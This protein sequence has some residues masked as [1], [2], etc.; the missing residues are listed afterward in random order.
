MNKYLN[1]YMNVQTYEHWSTIIS[2]HMT[3]ST[4]KEVQVPVNAWGLYKYEN[5]YS[6]KCKCKYKKL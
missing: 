6:W 3:A 4:G 5:E 2:A 1:G